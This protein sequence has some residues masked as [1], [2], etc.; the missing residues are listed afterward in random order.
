MT[1][2]NW[3][4]MAT[5]PAEFKD[6]RDVIVGFD[7]ASVWITRSAWWRKP[8]DN[9]AEFDADDE[10]WW[11]YRH[12]IT[13]EKLDEYMTP[14]HWLCEAPPPPDADHREVPTRTRRN[15]ATPF[16]HRVSGTV[17][18]FDS[19]FHVFCKRLGIVST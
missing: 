5:L 13:Q 4:P 7:V 17:D 10:G 6:G 1:P 14:T 2:F 18:L 9:P 16:G 3:K 11:S 19:A 8:E 12:S 15:E